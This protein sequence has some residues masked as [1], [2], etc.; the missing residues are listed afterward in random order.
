MKRNI[1]VI[2]FILYVLFISVYLFVADVP[3]ISG[4]INHD[5][6]VSISDLVIVNRYVNGKETKAYDLRWADMDGDG[7]ITLVD[8]ATIEDIILG[9]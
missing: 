7:D 2:L 8:V 4:D 6:E 3:G 5:G 1:S 9:R